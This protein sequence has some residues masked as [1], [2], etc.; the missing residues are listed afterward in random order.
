VIEATRKC[1]TWAPCRSHRAHPCLS[2]QYQFYYPNVSLIL[3]LLHARICATPTHRPT[4]PTSKY[5]FPVLPLR[6]GVLRAPC[7]ASFAEFAAAAMLRGN[8]FHLSS[9]SSSSSVC[10]KGAVSDALRVISK[11]A[12]APSG[13]V[14]VEVRLRRSLYSTGDAT[15]RVGLVNVGGIAIGNGRLRF[16]IACSLS[17][18]RDDFQAGGLLFLAESF[19]DLQPQQG[20]APTWQSAG[21]CAQTPTFTSFWE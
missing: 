15:A 20:L 1:Q 3:S 17:L 11:R 12:F 14:N 13:C 19:V 2:A 7:L 18:S 8:R 5:W 10:E 6:P 4:L 9:S 16:R 21:T